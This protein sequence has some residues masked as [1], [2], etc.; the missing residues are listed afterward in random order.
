MKGISVPAEYLNLNVILLTLLWMVI[1]LLAYWARGSRRP[2]GAAWFVGYL[3]GGA[4]MLTLVAWDYIQAGEKARL[5]IERR[6]RAGK[7]APAAA[8]NAGASKAGRRAKGQTSK[9]SGRR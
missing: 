7:S 9:V 4:L 5:E 1:G 3:L 8:S 2:A 6:R